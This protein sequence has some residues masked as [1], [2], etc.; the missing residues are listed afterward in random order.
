MNIAGKEIFQRKICIIS[1]STHTQKAISIHTQRHNQNYTK[2]K[3]SETATIKKIVTTYT[4]IQ[5]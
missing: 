5:E 3:F 4:E 2:K 1:C